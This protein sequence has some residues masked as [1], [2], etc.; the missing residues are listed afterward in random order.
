M[1]QSTVVAP[2]VGHPRHEDLIAVLQAIQSECHYLPQGTLVAVARHFGVPLSEVFHIA[3]FYNCFSLEPR[4]KH[5]LQVC[6]G[7]ACHVRGG[8]QILDKILR[9]LKMAAP[10]TSP[11]LEFSVEP[12]RCLG[13]CGL[14]PVMRVDK[15]TH[16]HLKQAVIPRILKSYRSK[17]EKPA[18][19]ASAAAGS[20]DGQD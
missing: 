7:T 13:C 9:D 2:T 20:T 16:G 6:L 14:A 4:G 18:A 11:D 1:N 10:G 15:R 5:M 19:A 8:Q 3:T 12:V 17:P